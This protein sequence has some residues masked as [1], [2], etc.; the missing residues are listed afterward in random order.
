MAGHFF[1]IHLLSIHLVV[2]CCFYW[3]PT[4]PIPAY[5]ICLL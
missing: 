4:N 5:Q 2:P 3:N 1:F